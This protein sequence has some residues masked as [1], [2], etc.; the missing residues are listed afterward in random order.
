[1]GGGIMGQED[2]CGFS[3]WGGGVE[4]VVEGFRY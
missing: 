2:N 4:G 3:E 1:M